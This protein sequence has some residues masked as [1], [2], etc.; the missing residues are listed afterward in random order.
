MKEADY[1][2]EFN[3]KVQCVLCP[4]RCIIGEGEEGRCMGKKNENGTLYAVNYGELAS[5]TVDPIEKKPLYHFHPTSG[6]L[7]TGP[8]GCNMICSFCQNKEISQNSI[9]TKHMEP[10]QLVEHASRKDSIGIAYTYT[11]PLIWWEYL[12]DTCPLA[13]ER[14]LKN[15]LVTNGFLNEEPLRELLPYIDAM[16]IDLKAMN[17]DFYGRICGGIMEDVL[18]NIRI[19]A[20]ETLVEITNLIIPGYNDSEEDIEEMVDFIASVDENIPLHLSAYTPRFKLQAESTP[21]ATLKRARETAKEKL[22]YVYIGNLLIKE[23]SNTVCP[24]CDSTL[25]NRRGFSTTMGKIED[26]RCESCDRPVDIVL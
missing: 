22:N 2:R 8:N 13:H 9:P 16:N 10:D 3:G 20:D 26:G 5:L 23:A 17:Q 1:W 11:E 4:V 24:G 19:C 18:R 21:A 7:S 12:M 6:I 25:I 14:G 15:V